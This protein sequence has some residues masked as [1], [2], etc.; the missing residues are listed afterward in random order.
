MLR[1]I[2][3]LSVCAVATPALAQAPP[4]APLIF[5]LPASARIGALGNAWVAGRDQDVIFHNP[6]QIIGA[7][8]PF[9]VTID[10][11]GP[12]ATAFTV[13]N[14]FAAGKYSLTLG[15]GAR[16]L[17]F[18]TDEFAAYPYT[19]DDLL[20]KGLADGQSMLV[21]FAGGI[22]Y[23]NF[24]IGGATK[25]VSDR[26]TSLPGASTPVSIDQHAW[27]GDI[28]VARNLWTG[29]AAFSVQN[30]GRTTAKDASS[31][32][33]PRQFVAGY[34]LTRVAGPLDLGMYGQVTMRKDWWAPAGGLEAG[35]SWIEGY[36]VTLRVGAM[37]PETT[38]EQPITLGAALNADRL[39]LEYAVRFFDHGCTANM[40]T[41]RWR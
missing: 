28:G 41:V 34:S 25:F 19:Q 35:Y 14:S 21:T 10:R 4:T 18:R 22:V 37:R 11:P 36:S 3:F 8:R 9:G 23:K 31:L 40:V 16:F 30:L 12:S 38:R 17:D 7:A 32:V 1:P 20:N 29:V 13:A 26:V 2:V 39:T 27:L 6:A 24:R 15:Y 5:H 33:T